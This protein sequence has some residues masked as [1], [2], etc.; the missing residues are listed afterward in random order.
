MSIHCYYEINLHLVWHTKN[1]SLLLT[2]RIEP[3]AYH[4]LKKRVVETPGAF[5]HAIGGTA[6]HVHLAVNI[7][8][9]LTISDWIGALKGG[10]S[11][12]VNE[13]AGELAKVLQ[14]QSGY[15]VVSFGTGDLDWVKAYI[16]N[17]KEHHHVGKIADRLER[18]IELAP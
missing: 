8:P 5:L 6:T 16:A 15:G 10:S 13:A 18:C 12:D 7:P 14:W 3:Q 1:S 17:Q 11:H 9:T 4:H 2:P